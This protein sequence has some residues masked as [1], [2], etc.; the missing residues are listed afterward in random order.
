[1]DPALELYSLLARGRS[2]GFLSRTLQ[3]SVAYRA[4][5]RSSG[6]PPPP[7]PDRLAIGVE[8]LGAEWRLSMLALWCSAERSGALG[9]HAAQ[10]LH[11]DRGR[12]ELEQEDGELPSGFDVP[13]PPAQHGQDQGL[14]LVLLAWD[15]SPELPHTFR[16]RHQQPAA[17][18][19]APKAPALRG[20]RLCGLVPA[21]AL[22][23]VLQVPLDRLSARSCHAMRL[24]TWEPE[25]QQ[26]QQQQQQQRQLL[27][28]R[29][30]QPA[31]GSSAHS[32]Q[33]KH[34]RLHLQLEQQQ[35]QQQR[36]QQQQQAQPPQACAAAAAAAA[37]PP[38][39][40]WQQL[41]RQLRQ[42][43]RQ[44]PMYHGIE[45][46]DLQ[47]DTS[48]LQRFISFPGRGLPEALQRMYIDRGGQEAAVGDELPCGACPLCDE[49][50]HLLHGLK[51]HLQASH[52]HL[53]WAAALGCAR[54]VPM[55]RQAKLPGCA[56]AGRLVWWTGAG[57]KAERAGPPSAG[58]ATGPAWSPSGQSR[59]AA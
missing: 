43:L 29:F 31:D 1:M 59:R 41:R 37:E 20:D 47:L 53:R 12:C 15:A 7:P 46:Q 19:S 10:L 51:L 22:V 54:A 18:T 36:Q 3:Y 23:W 40:E 33:L 27:L 17:R 16:S 48:A 14:Q 38:L 11:L 2:R 32:N 9:V 25:L 58:S 34:A 26:Q 21:G 30:S 50:C 5:Q 45:A 24:R 4:G 28:I 42:L 55:L 56:V 13:P 52:A 8:G 39:S 49:R 57:R 35:Q 44:R 6:A